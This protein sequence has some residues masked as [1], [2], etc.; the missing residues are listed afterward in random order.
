MFL[1]PCSLQPCFNNGVC[2][3][4]DYEF[5]CDCLTGY[6]GDTCEISRN[7]FTSYFFKN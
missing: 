5:V 2:T 3:D 4:Y 1:A 6:S 7:F